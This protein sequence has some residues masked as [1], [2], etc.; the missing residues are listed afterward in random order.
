MSLKPVPFGEVPALT[1]RVARAA[2][3]KGTLCMR[4]RDAV[5]Q[6]FS[7]E[8]FAELFSSR[9]RAGWSPARLAWVLVLQFVE[10]LTDRAAADAVR[11]R[12]DWKYLMGLDLE[13]PGF[14]F[15]VLSEFRDRLVTA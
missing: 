9:G 11:S 3:P 7:D 4:I 15:S 2:F 13:D 5:G 14:D 12:I 1:A 8:Q 10:N 6:V